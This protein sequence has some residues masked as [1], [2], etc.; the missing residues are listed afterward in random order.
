ML[1]KVE[2]PGAGCCDL[3][4]PHGTQGV[5]HIAH[6][7]KRDKGRVNSQRPG[8]FFQQI[9]CCSSVVWQRFNVLLRGGRVILSPTPM[10]PARKTGAEKPRSA[11]QAKASQAKALTFYLAHFRCLLKMKFITACFSP[12]LLKLARHL[13]QMSTL[14]AADLDNAFPSR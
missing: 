1:H 2:Y 9:L 13:P 12:L 10:D 14:E 6:D 7:L 3:Y 8:F 5:R 11:Q 4:L